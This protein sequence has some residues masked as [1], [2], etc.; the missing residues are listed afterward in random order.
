M[1]SKDAGWQDGPVV[2][3]TLA[4]LA[5]RRVLG[6]IGCGPAPDGAAKNTH[7]ISTKIGKTTV[8]TQ[9]PPFNT[10][11]RGVH[12]Q[13]P[14]AQGEVA[15][16]RVRRD[17]VADLPPAPV[18]HDIAEAERKALGV[19]DGF[20][21]LV[22]VESPEADARTVALAADA[23]GRRRPADVVLSFLMPYRTPRRLEVGSGLPASCW[24]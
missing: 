18:E 1:S 12:R 16:H 19:V 5:L 21:V 17:P 3:R 20:R 11:D 9:P 7:P 8:P 13:P 14:A 22:A 24:R 4:F 15:P 2:V 10:V 23:V 6:V